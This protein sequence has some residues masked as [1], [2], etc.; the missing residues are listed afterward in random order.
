MTAM[1]GETASLL[2]VHAACSTIVRMSAGSVKSR[3]RR[4]VLAAASVSGALV[5]SAARPAGPAGRGGSGPKALAGGRG[6]VAAAGGAR[7]R[8]PKK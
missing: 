2:P 4:Y 8:A 5:V 3:S 7:P 6:G 1:S